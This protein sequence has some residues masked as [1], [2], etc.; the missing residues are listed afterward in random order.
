MDC[1]Y[2]SYHR[3][4]KWVLENRNDEIS[5]MINA[6][7]PSFFEFSSNPKEII[8]LAD[9]QHKWTYGHP[10]DRLSSAKIQILTHPDEWTL[11]GDNDDNSTGHQPTAC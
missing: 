2:F 3:P 8:Y 10:L 9:S 1:N 5:G 6:Y 7:G 11:N 4:P